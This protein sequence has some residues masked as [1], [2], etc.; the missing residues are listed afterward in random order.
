MR[1]I[2][3]RVIPIVLFVLLSIFLWRGL[4]LNPH[5]LPS[6]QVGKLVPD[7]TLPELHHPESSFSSQNIRNQVVLL[8]VWASWCAACTDEQV[9]MLQLARE[10]MPIYGLNYKDK[11]EDALQWLSQWG[12]PYK[13][14]M[15]DREGRAAIDLGVYGAPETFVIDKKGVIRYRHAGVMNQELWQKEVLPLIKQLEQMA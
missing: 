15:Q 6:V 7:F 5:N 14:V 8:N 9:F 2:G 13:L 11:P 12:N 3:W 10:G 4:S 1:K